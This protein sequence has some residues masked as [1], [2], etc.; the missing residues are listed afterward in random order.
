MGKGRTD[1]RRQRVLF[2]ELQ[3]DVVLPYVLHMVLCIMGISQEKPRDGSYIYTV[4]KCKSPLGSAGKERP[5]FNRKAI[6]HK[7]H[8]NSASKGEAKLITEQN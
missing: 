3:V 5:F 7:P 8:S 4:R 6:Q 1:W 2:S